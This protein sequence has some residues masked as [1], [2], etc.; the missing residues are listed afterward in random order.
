MGPRRL[1]IGRV[2]RSNTLGAAIV[3]VFVKLARVANIPFLQADD[4]DVLLIVFSDLELLAFIEEVVEFAAVNL[5]ERKFGFEVLEARLRYFRFT[6][7][8]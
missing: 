1:R 2:F 3:H 6:S 7:A 8:K 4:V 5:K